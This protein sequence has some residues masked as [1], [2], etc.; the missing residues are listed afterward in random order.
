MKNPTNG[1]LAQT[2]QTLE[3]YNPAL[4]AGVEKVALVLQTMAL[5]FL[6]VLFIIELQN[7]AKKLNSD[8]GGLTMEIVTSIG[9]RYLVAFLMVM[10]SGEILDFIMWLAIQASKWVSSVLPEGTYNMTVPGIKGKVGF[11]EKPIVFLFSAI[12]QLAV[13]TNSYIATIIIFLRAIQLFIF[14]ALAPIFVVFVMS[15][16]LKSIGIGF[17]KQFSAYALQ[18][19]VLVLLMGIYPALMQ[20]DFLAGD[21]ATGMDAWLTNIGVFFL[22]FLKA[23]VVLVLII[24]SQNL[25]KRLIGGG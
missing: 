25:A 24:G 16:E 1:S 14:K 4:N 18:G 10:A 5:F 15:E 7:Y 11:F 19:V 8:D 22:I 3:E 9:M 13:W 20:N 2:F 12:A 21:V 6:I 23:L 17:L